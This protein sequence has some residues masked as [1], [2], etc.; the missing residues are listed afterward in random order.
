MF[1]L[2]AQRDQLKVQLT[3]INNNVIQ[4][5]HQIEELKM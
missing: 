2:A 5:R 1:D 4:F 3:V